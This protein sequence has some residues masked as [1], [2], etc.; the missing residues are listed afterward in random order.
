MTKNLELAICIS[1]VDILMNGVGL[2]DYLKIRLTA[3]SKEL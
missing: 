3:L 2:E 1:R